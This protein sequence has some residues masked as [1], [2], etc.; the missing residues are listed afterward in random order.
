MNGPPDLLQ[1]LPHGPEFRFVDAVTALEPGRRAVSRYR[2]RGDEAFLLG[3]FP[4][5]PVMPGVLLVEALA[6]TGGLAAQS[7]RIRERQAR[8][9]LAAIHQV[10]IFGTAG[11]GAELETEARVLGRIGGLVEVEGETRFCGRILMRGRLT[12]GERETN[13]ADVLA[14]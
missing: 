9:Y 14:R 7:E 3:H 1:S 8:L 6:Q 10:R 4:G 13:D 5:D 2:L 12:L 11:P